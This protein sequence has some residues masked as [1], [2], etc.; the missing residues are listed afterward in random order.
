MFTFFWN[1]RFCIYSWHKKRI[2]LTVE[3][4]TG[5]QL[6]VDLS[7]LGD[8]SITNLGEIEGSINY[9]N[10][11]TEFSSVTEE[12]HGYYVALNFNPWSGNKFRIDRTTGNGKEVAFNGD[13]ICI[14]RL[15]G[16]ISEA[17]TAECITVIDAEGNEEHYYLDVT[18]K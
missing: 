4:A 8:Y 11:W 1:G 10:N 7:T 2:S 16:N 14:C 15:G 12:Q 6:G 18:F 3:K 5:T 13:G 9:I 17:N